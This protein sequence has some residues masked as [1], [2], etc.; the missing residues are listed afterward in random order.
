MTPAGR[1]LLERYIAAER[2]G[3]LVRFYNARGEQYFGIALFGGSGGEKAAALKLA[4]DGF[5]NFKSGASNRH[6][7]LSITDAGREAIGI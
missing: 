5:A 7:C 2:A 1:K 3:S 6:S 4:R